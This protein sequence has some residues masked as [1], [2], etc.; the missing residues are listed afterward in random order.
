L[1]NRPSTEK[2]SCGEARGRPK[3]SKAREQV[4]NNAGKAFVKYG[5][6]A[7]TVEHILEETGVSRTNFYRFFKNKEEVFGSIFQ[8][9]LEELREKMQGSRKRLDKE[10]SAL[11]KIDRLFDAYLEACF[12]VEELLPILVEESQ[13]L[14]EYRALKELTFNRFKKNMTEILVQG[15]Y[16]KP[17]PL[18]LEGVLAAVDR[19]LLIESK[20]NKN[21]SSKKKT[22]K[23]ICMNF[24]SLLVN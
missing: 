18:M 1:A 4:V 21:V 8:N 16:Q 5:Y 11:E 15:G 17:D 23:M 10:S 19:V 7:C 6:H 12:S 2:K 13:T 3:G 24:V 22:V 9:S 14:P 20:K